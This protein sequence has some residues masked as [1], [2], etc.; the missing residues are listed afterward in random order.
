[1]DAFFTC[2]KRW[3]SW[4]I[5]KRKVRSR[6]PRDASLPFTTIYRRLVFS[7]L[8]FSQTGTRNVNSVRIPN[9][10]GK[11]YF[12]DGHCRKCFLPSL[13][14]G[15]S[16][17]YQQISGRDTSDINFQMELCNASAPVTLICTT[18]NADDYSC[19]FVFE[20]KPLIIFCSFITIV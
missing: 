20:K 14:Y 6:M 13:N 12:Y 18:N 10:S 4:P 2:Q 8:H 9:S 16:G 11:V 5:N 15:A 7:R 19:S 17:I 3:K 1:M